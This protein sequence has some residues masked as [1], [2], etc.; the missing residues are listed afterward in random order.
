M[1][2]IKH[3]SDNFTIIDCNLNDRNQAEILKELTEESS[4][5]E[6]SRFISTHPDEDHISGLSD[7]EEEMGISN[8]Y[9]V[10]NNATKMSQ[11]KVLRHTKLSEIL[12]R[13]FTYIKL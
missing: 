6:I 11:V 10:K 3:G 13:R 8:F 2:Y 1:F 4:S 7:I 5:K 9:C 12:L